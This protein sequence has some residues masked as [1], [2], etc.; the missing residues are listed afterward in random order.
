[1]PRE[2]NLYCNTI[3]CN[4]RR[5]LPN[6]LVSQ[7]FPQTDTKRLKMKLSF[8]T[9]PT[10]P[11]EVTISLLAFINLL[12]FMD[13]GIIPGSTVEF[14][15][16]IKDTTHTSSPD[17]LLGLLQSSFVVGFVVGSVL[18]GH[19]VH[20][21]DKF[22]LIR[23]GMSI[24]IVAVLFSG[25]AYYTNSYEFLIIVRM[26]SGFGEASLQ[27]TAPP[28]IQEHASP[29]FRGIWLSIYY[30]S[31]PLGTALGYAYS[32]TIS[33]SSSWQ[34]AFFGEVFIMSPILIYLFQ[35]NEE[36]LRINTL[37]PTTST[38]TTT[39]ITTS[40]KDNLQQEL[41]PV[42]PINNN[43]PG[44]VSEG[45][46]ESDSIHLLK[47]HNPQNKPTLYQELLTICQTPIYLAL[48]LGNAAQTATIMGLATFGSAFMMGLGYFDSES[49]ASTM[50]GIYV[51]LAGV[52]GTPIGGYIVD[53]LA[54]PYMQPDNNS[55]NSNDNS[56][57]NSNNNNNS[58]SAN[59]NNDKNNSNNTLTHIVGKNIFLFLSQIFLVIAWGSLL[60]TFLLCI[61]YLVYD[62]NAYLALITIGCLFIFLTNVGI[63]MG[64]MISVPLIH[65]SFAVAFGAIIGHVLGDVP[66][67]VIAGWLKDYLAPD[68]VTSA[69]DDTAS[70]N[71]LTSDACRDEGDRIRLCFFLI[72]VWMAWAAVCFGVGY[73]YCRRKVYELSN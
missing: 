68:C 29:K 15:H 51:S 13:R 9:L 52:L 61:V 39:T 41:S 63:Y 31:N 50:F 28:W 44:E 71:V 4:F 42:P 34:W 20:Y 1:M 14:N 27:C 70:S 2:I 12:N 5:N 21:Y 72:S 16:F 7:N 65:R 33:N 53:Q 10:P 60:G 3:E 73:Y 47:D 49:E 37:D 45:E 19:M 46:V 58:N 26:F 66:S 22:T 23:M 62:K 8:P 64:F 48:I 17:I 35:L 57:D 55:T 54:K 59:N 43:N 56:N 69:D 25:V 36:K 67:P 6:C 18:F 38:T 24:W 32:S 30:T 40:S 11:T